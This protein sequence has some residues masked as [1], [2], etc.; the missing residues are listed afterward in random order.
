MLHSEYDKLEGVRSSK[1]LRLL[2]CPAAYNLPF[3]ETPSLLFGRAFHSFLL[4]PEDFVCSYMIKPNFDGRTKS[5]KLNILAFYNRYE[6]I[7]KENEY[8]SI[9]TNEDFEQIKLMATSIR[10]HPTA[11][12]WINEAGESEV[13]AQ[14]IDEETGIKCKTLADWII[15]NRIIDVKTIKK[16]YANVRSFFREAVYV[17]KYH[18]SGAM[19]LDGF[20]QNGKRYQ[21]YSFIVVEKEPP[22][23]VCCFDMDTS[24]IEDGY[25]EYKRLLRVLKQ[26]LDSNQWPS[27]DNAGSELLIS[28]KEG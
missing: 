8:L 22:Y 18:V 23:K 13:C 2:D 17:Y 7:K 9:I 6:A 14:W 24:L 25:N 10:E 11:S 1:L 4:Q 20:L 27:Y 15:P 12:A 3:E 21:D 26:H 5:G 16:G 19:R 28:H